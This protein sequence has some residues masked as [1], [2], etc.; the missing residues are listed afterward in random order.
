MIEL[1]EVTKTYPNGTEAVK[2]LSFTVRDGET[3]VLLGPSGCGKTTAMKLINRLI[4]AT[5]GG[6]LID[7][8]DNK[9]IDVN[10][11]RRS[12]GF[13]IQDVGLFPHMTVGQNIATV[14]ALKGWSK[15]R[16]RERALELLNLLRLDPKKFID[17][18]PHELS[19][20][21][22][23]RVGVARAL[24]ADPPILLMD[25][26]FGAID[27]ITRMELQNEFLKIQEQ[28]KKTVIFVTHDISEAIKIGDQVALMKAGELVQF[29]P[30]VDL[31]FNPNTD[32]AKSFT[33]VDSP[34]KGFRRCRWIPPCP[35]KLPPPNLTTNRTPS[36]KLMDKEDLQWLPVIDDENK[37]LGMIFRRNLRK[38]EIVSKILSNNMAYATKN[39]TLDQA[40]SL[41]L[42][43]G[44]NS[45][46]VVDEESGNFEGVITFE[47]LQKELSAL[48][49]K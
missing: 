25:E 44:Q 6:I 14:P 3:C 30:P 43:S 15:T 29:G 23:Q 46:A 28:I 18:Y 40:L 17:K 34:L 26:P 39:M 38:A 48:Y 47:K 22:R 36:G 5:S 24:G 7:G 4:P 19:G 33:G 35:M 42:T 10:E 45:L 41:L 32:F 12:I 31:I 37:Y 1:V 8:V 9:K 2:R 16:R 49:R 11:L 20:G 13:A 27:P 21:Q